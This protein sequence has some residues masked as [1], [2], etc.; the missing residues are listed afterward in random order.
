M[1]SSS[2]SSTSS[3]SLASSSSA[4]AAPPSPEPSSSSTSSST[5]SSS[6]SRAES[7]AGL[8]LYT[9]AQLANTRAFLDAVRA[10]LPALQ[11]AWVGADVCAW[12]HVRCGAAGV[13]LALADAALSGRLAELPAVDASLV[14][15]AVVDVGGNAGVAGT[16]PASWGA[17][18]ALTR[19]SVAG[20]SV[21]GPLPAAWGALAALR[22]LD[23]SDTLVSGT[24]PA[25]WGGA[26]AR[27]SVLR[28]RGAAL[29]GPLP[30]AWGALAALTEL[31][32]R[33]NRLRGTLPAS[34]GALVQLETLLVSDNALEGTLPVAYGD[35]SRL[36]RFDAARNALVGSVPLVFGLLPA[37]RD[38]VLDGNRFCGCLP[39][40]WQS[41]HGGDV[42]VRV[43]AD[44]ALMDG[45]CAWS[46]YCGATSTYPVYAQTVVSMCPE[47]VSYGEAG[48][49]TDRAEIC[50]TVWS[51]PGTPATVC[52]DAIGEFH[53]TTV[54]CSAA[55]GTRGRLSCCAHVDS[56]GTVTYL[57]ER[58][59]QE[60]QIVGVLLSPYD[61]AA[62]AAAVAP[63]L[64]AALAA[65]WCAVTM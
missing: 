43:V 47:A 46:N 40:Q 7:D 18:A 45:T 1:S 59:T 23:V 37:V 4:G 33:R 24:L 48:F 29:S 35:M 65:L 58:C 16:L 31:D 17:L 28:A 32:L 44:A 54:T 62:A 21:D 42:N 13:E 8:A 15:V 57:G 38:V 9:A 61:G 63:V 10:G 41:A 27:L 49:E 36:I 30:A 11:T 5:C 55:L 6:S 19:V 12:A 22:E 60:L 2:T 14:V 25:A 3:A 20:T 39:P 50:C 56:D 64:V 52:G 51:V 53:N 34:W 26:L